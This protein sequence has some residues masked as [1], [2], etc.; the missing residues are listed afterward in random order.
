MEAIENQ[1]E[2]GVKNVSIN[3]HITRNTLIQKKKAKK[4]KMKMK[5]FQ[6]EF[7]YLFRQLL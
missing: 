2:F 4:Q 3:Q 5:F 6:K 7:K 1:E